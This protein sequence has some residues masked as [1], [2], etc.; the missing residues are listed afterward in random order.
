M[1]HRELHQRRA[2]AAHR[3]EMAIERILGARTDYER[4][5]AS[6]WA[7]AWRELSRGSEFVAL[8]RGR[9]VH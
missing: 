1:A 2:Y 8:S 4:T 9:S 3:M 6:K 7:Y 5:M